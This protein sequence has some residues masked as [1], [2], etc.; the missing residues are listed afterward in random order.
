MVS[1]CC[2]VLS[3]HV[4]FHINFL[5][6]TSTSVQIEERERGREVNLSLYSTMCRVRRSA[7]FSHD[8][9]P[10]KENLKI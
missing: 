3:K 4:F 1:L 5:T 8:I 2:C 9:Y 6:P 7:T 10:L